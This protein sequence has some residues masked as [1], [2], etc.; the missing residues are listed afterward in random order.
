LAG[1]NPYLTLSELAVDD[2]ASGLM[3]TANT[4]TNIKQ[5]QG[6]QGKHPIRPVYE[7]RRKPTRLVLRELRT[8]TQSIRI[9][10]GTHAEHSVNT[11]EHTWIHDT[12]SEKRADM[13]EI[14]ADKKPNQASFG[15]RI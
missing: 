6:V 13:L 5:V 15:Y 14:P 9:I 1:V 10:W 4:K 7:M 8:D 3:C 11:Q 12:Q 2:D